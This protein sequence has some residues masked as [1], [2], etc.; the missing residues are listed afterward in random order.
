M[1]IALASDIHLEFGDIV[2]DNDQ[3]ADVLILSGDICVVRELVSK[4]ITMVRDFFVNCSQR[5]GK[6]I[7]VM[8]NH[9]HYR[10]DFAKSHEQAQQVFNDLGLSNIHLLEKSAVTIDDVTFVGGTLWTDC[11]SQDS[12]TM[13]HAGRGMSDYRVIQ[14][15][16]SGKSGGAWRLIPEHTVADHYRM[17]DYV[18]A[19]VDGRPDQKFVVVG[20]HA[21]SFK[22]VDEI[23]QHDTLMNGNFFTNLEQFI[24]DRPQIKVWTHGHMHNPSDYSIGETRVVCN[25]RGYIGHEDRAVNFELFYFDL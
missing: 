25:P 1:K 10:G 6:V 13:W 14:N 3:A 17:K 7:Y 23:Y 24:Q 11:N 5:F 21:P 4:D 2:L 19:V 18:R 20:H 8:G 9:E 16:R 15:T 12:M 22:S